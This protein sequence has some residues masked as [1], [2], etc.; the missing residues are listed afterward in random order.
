[1]SRQVHVLCRKQ[2]IEKRPNTCPELNFRLTTRAISVPPSLGPCALGT[3]GLSEV[4]CTTPPSAG[5]SRGERTS[6]L[7]STDHRQA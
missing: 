4:T 3:S 1:M 5:Q 7:Q 2:R 6:T